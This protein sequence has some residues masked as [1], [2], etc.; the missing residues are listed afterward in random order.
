MTPKNRR[1]SGKQCQYRPTILPSPAGVYNGTCWQNRRTS[2]FPS[3][4]KCGKKALFCS[5]RIMWSG[6]ALHLPTSKGRDEIHAHDAGTTQCT[7]SPWMK[8]GGRSTDFESRCRSR[9]SPLLDCI[10]REGLLTFVISSPIIATVTDRNDAPGRIIYIGACL[11]AAVRLAREERWDNSPRVASRI[12][13]AIQLAKRIYE[14]MQSDFG[15]DRG[16]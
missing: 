16:A 5:H 12:A 4:R 3:S 9:I 10:R 7:T 2:R 1:A 6:Q 15:R 11:I 8:A 14:R 13:D